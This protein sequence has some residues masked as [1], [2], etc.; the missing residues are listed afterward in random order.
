MRAYTWISPS[1]IN[2]APGLTA[3]STTRLPSRAYTCWPARTGRS[4]TRVLPV[5]PSPPPDTC[6]A[7]SGSA[8][9]G[10][11]K[12]SGTLTGSAGSATGA[13]GRSSLAGNHPQPSA[14]ACSPTAALLWRTPMMRTPWDCNS[15]HSC[16]RASATLSSSADTSSRKGSLANAFGRRASR[17]DNSLRSSSGSAERNSRDSTSSEADLISRTD[18]EWV[19]V[20]V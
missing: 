12:D 1:A 15:S 13:D 10:S 2:S 14:R 17:A 8:A 6:G 11:G 9:T 5:Q 16:G 19:A 7:G 18:R 4:T 20:M 3:A